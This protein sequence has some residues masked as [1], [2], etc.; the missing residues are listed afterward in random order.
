MIQP[1]ETFMVGNPQLSHVCKLFNTGKSQLPS[2]TSSK[3]DSSKVS[4]LS[5]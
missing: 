3:Y 4:F 5:F 2:M 1:F